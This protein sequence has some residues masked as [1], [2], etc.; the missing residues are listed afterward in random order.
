MNCRSP[1]LSIIIPT[2]NRR[3]ILAQLLDSISRLKEL[4]RI[5]PEV[6]VADNGSD[7]DTYEYV[8]STSADFPATLR[9]LKVPRGGKSAAIN[10]AAKAATGDILAFLDDD[11]VV[12]GTWLTALEEIF[13]EG[14][15]RIGQG[16]IRLQSPAI[17]DPEV[18]RLVQRYRTI[19]KLEYGA[20]LTEVRSL[21]GS[22][23]FVC[24]DLFD[25]V[26]G[27]DERLGPGAS[28]T[29]EDVDFARRVTLAS[30][31]I[32]YVPQAVVYHR[33]DR[34]RLTDAYFRQSH[35]HQGKSRFLI[36][37][38][39]AVEILFNLVHSC[40]QYVFYTVV[41]KERNRY[42]SKGRIYHYLGMMDAK[43]N[44]VDHQQPR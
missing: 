38:R 32:G 11:V 27:F 39:S 36:R 13:R 22:N 10:E 14:K 17:D 3:Q 40:A 16:I 2:K 18:Q 25:H 26:G 23:F 34:N 31:A 42:R 20:H 41:A 7:D 24:R 43:R 19:P 1:C 37:N 5:C 15:Y 4:N 9:A 21:N 44:N 30:V 12:D 8:N 29:S 6:I 28:G 33:V 35:W